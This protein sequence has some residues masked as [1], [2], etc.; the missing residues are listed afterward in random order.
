MNAETTPRSQS[1]V[2]LA[3]DRLVDSPLRPCQPSIILWQSTNDADTQRVKCITGCD[4]CMSAQQLNSRT[5]SPYVRTVLLA[6]SFS[7]L[8]SNRNVHLGSMQTNSRKL[9]TTTQSHAKQL[10]VLASR[11]TGPSPDQIPGLQG[12]QVDTSQ[13]QNSPAV[14][15]QDQCDL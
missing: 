13:A 12:C 7:S 9:K 14:V 1:P 10:Y 11:A 6:S 2:A 15:Q 3:R 5:S 8:P 4:Y